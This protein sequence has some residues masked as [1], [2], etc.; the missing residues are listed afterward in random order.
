[1]MNLSDFLVLLFCLPIFWILSFLL[2]E[3]FHIKSQGILSNGEI[4]V[5]GARL[6]SRLSNIVD[7]KI[8]YYSGGVCSG[9]V[10]IILGFIFLHYN[11]VGAYIPAYSVGLINLIYGLYEGKK[12]PIED[13]YKL[14]LL[15]GSALLAFWILFLG[16]L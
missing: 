5:D 11:A 16:F 3:L 15:V 10:F 8:L 7:E 14:Y 13:R 9:L 2:H 4:V 12:Y 1:M 6:S